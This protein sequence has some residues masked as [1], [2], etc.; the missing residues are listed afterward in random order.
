MGMSMGK[1]DYRTKASIISMGGDSRVGSRWPIAARPSL[2]ALQKV[3]QGFAGLGPETVGLHNEFQDAVQA[4][5]AEVVAQLAP[6]RKQP[7]RAEVGKAQR[8][9]RTL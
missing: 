7:H 9:H 1:D 8:A 2:I 4:K 6:G 3:M 5:R